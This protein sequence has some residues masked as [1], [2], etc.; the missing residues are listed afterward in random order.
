[1]SVKINGK[2]VHGLLGW[3]IA[4]PVLVFT[5]LVTA[6]ILLFGAVLVTLPVT[7]PFFVLLILIKIFLKI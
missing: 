7:I 2:E 6:A 5:F 3:L 1:M 4:I